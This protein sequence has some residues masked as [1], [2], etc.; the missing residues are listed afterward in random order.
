MN[1]I[2]TKLGENM[3]L[4]EIVSIK[5]IGKR[6]TVDISVSDDKLFW[7]N[8]ILVHNSAAGFF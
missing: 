4:D 2:I 3:F 5:K 8:G 1:K 7:C 6:K